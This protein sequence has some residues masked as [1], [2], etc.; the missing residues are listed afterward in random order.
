MSPS[1]SDIDGIV[2]GG[3]LTGRCW[4][5]ALGNG[6]LELSSVLWTGCIAY[7]LNRVIFFRDK[8]QA[9][10][11]T[12]PK[13]LAIVFGVPIILVLL[14]FLQGPQVYGPAGGHAPWCWI[15]PEFPQW[16]FIC[17]YVPL[18]ITMIYNA[19]V[20]LRTVRQLKGIRSQGGDA[21]TT[22]RFQ[23]IMQRLKFYPF[24][25]LI[26][27]GPA[28]VNR[29]LEA[30]TEG[31]V[32]L[33]PL[34]FLQ[35]VFSSS[36]GLLNACAYGLSRGIREAV[37]K[38]L[39]SFWLWCG[40]KCGA[41]ASGG[42]GGSPAV[43]SL[44]LAASGGSSTSKQQNLLDGALGGAVDT[45]QVSVAGGSIFPAAGGD[46]SNST[47]AMATVEEDDEDNIENV[48]LPQRPLGSI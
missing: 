34:Y 33:F 18:W 40:G 11:K 5:Q 37:E 24:I 8:I 12:L 29:I 35:R 45:T 10:E 32:S 26:V 3:P 27:W 38:D 36:Q 2:N 25:L 17:F 48:P 1:P 19:F 22:A 14:P 16:V 43:S 47:R 42:R 39:R 20:H 15:R 13:L 7:T 30:V 28:S 23:L 46:G 41:G 21:A 44:A 6:I 9:V 4:A 31:R